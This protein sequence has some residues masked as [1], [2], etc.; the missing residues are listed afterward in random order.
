IGIYETGVEYHFY[1]TLALLVIGWMYKTRPSSMLKWAAN[2]MLVGI[3]LFSGSL[4]LLATRSVLGIE[5]WWFLGPL[6]PI[7]G[8]FFIIG[9]AMLGLSFGK[10][11][12]ETAK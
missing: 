1:H 7:G 3:L 6:T 10:G 12:E 2:C 5:H 4:Y 11:E 8:V 9:W